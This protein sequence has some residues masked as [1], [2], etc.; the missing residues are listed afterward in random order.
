MTLP[1][2][3]GRVFLFLKYEVFSWTLVSPEFPARTLEGLSEEC[4][5]ASPVGNARA[6]RH[7]H[8]D[9]V[10]VAAVTAEPIPTNNDAQEETRVCPLVGGAASRSFAP[11]GGPI[12]K[13]RAR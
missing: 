2:R 11:A 10:S 1:E 5:Q 7:P 9:S 13:A 12:W 8:P 6:T 4:R 3:S